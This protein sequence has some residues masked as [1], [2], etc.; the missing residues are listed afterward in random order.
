MRFY[1]SDCHFYH[2]NLNTHM[3]NRGFESVEEMNQFMIERWNKKVRKND[4]IVIL[5]D[6]SIAGARETEELIK[7]LNGR[8]TLIIG[9]HDKYLKDKSFNR[10]LFVKITP[11][12]ELND[13]KRKVVLN[14]YPVFCYNG[15]NRVF[16]DGTPST[17]ML[18][19]HVHDTLDEKLV[20][21]FVEIT[22]SY[23]RDIRGKEQSIPCEM[24]NCFCMKSNYE[25]LTLDEWID[26]KGKKENVKVYN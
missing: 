2:K 10:S 6:L 7:K 22:K 4:E 23:K 3:D 16:E 21:Q 24:I 19:G 15:Q 26:L 18:Y 9:N 12:L 5:G 14:H 1:I 20:R 13:D 11:Y 8:K 25:P 17:Y